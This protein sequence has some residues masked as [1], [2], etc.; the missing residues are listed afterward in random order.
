MVRGASASAQLKS[1]QYPQPTPAQ[2]KLYSVGSVSTTSGYQINLLTVLVLQD[3]LQRKKGT[4]MGA[5]YWLS[6][7]P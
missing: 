3:S 4:E 1:T 6:I 5:V 7:W 2:L